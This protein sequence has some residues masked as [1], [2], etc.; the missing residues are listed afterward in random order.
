MNQPGRDALAGHLD[1]LL[2]GSIATYPLD[3][4]LVDQARRVF[5]R[6]PMAQR[7]YARLRNLADN[8]PAWT[9]AQ[10]LG[11]AGQRYFVRPSG[12]PLTE[13]VPGVFTVAGLSGAVCCRA[14]PRPRSKPPASPGCSGPEVA[15]QAGDP[16]RLEADV[17]ALYAADYV[18][19]WEALLQDLVLPPVVGLNAS[20]EAL[21]LLGAPNS[22]M[23]DLLRGIARSSRRARRRKCRARPLPGPPVPPPRPPRVP[24]P[25][26]A[27]RVAAAVGVQLGS[28]AAPVAEV[29]ERH[30]Q[31]LR[32]ASGQP[33]DGVLA[34]LNDLYVQVARLANSPPG[35]VMPPSVGLDP[36]QRLLSEAQ[37]QPAPLRAWMT[38][39]AQA[40]GR[41]VR[42]ARSRPSRRPRA[43]VVVVVVVVA[44][45]SSR[46]AAASR[47]AS[48]SVAS[49]M[50]R[51]CRWMTLSGSSPR[52]APSTP[53]SP[54]ICAPMST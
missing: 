13:G 33:L 43:V 2:A 23:K 1:A 44:G 29:V 3:G 25:G 41:A 48:P 8:T 30:F 45:A 6:L 46:F 38:A 35:T 49:P 15:T 54:N 32:E 16:R 37:R 5:S 28:G 36:G 53:S 34:I 26:A 21:N 20:A 4:A 14:C 50:R 42:A 18:R 7:V 31:A 40:T 12:R 39:L 9:P 10:A 24:P 19:A 27:S 52:A 11:A 47:R 22:P 51:T 17:L